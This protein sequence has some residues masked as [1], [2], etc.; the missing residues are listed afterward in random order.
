MALKHLLE[1]II[2]VR[3]FEEPKVLPKIISGV[4]VMPTILE[5]EQLSIASSP[6]QHGSD[7]V[8]G[9]DELLLQ[10]SPV[11]EPS[12]KVTYANN[13]Q[14]KCHRVNRFVRNMKSVF[15]RSD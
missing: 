3:A 12:M 4:S 15:K 11:L 6:V 14:T 8:M 2:P 7:S 13:Q 10:P 5:E 1:H 9:E